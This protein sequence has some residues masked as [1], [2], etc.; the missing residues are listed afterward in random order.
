MS[1]KNSAQKNR[2]FL[3]S[4]LATTALGVA[5]GVAG[6]MFMLPYATSL[7][8]QKATTTSQSMS[9][10]PRPRAS[11][12]ATASALAPS[13]RA[14]VSFASVKSAAGIA[15]KAY[16]PGDAI[17]MGAV[18]TSDG[19]MA[20]VSDSAVF[21]NKSLAGVTAL[22]GG[23]AYKVSRM[24][25]DAYSGVTFLKADADNLPVTAFGATTT[26]AVGDSVF[27]AD[28]AGGLRRLE[29]LA[30]DTMPATVSDDLLRSSEKVQRVIRVTSGSASAGAMVLSGKGEIIGLVQGD[31]RFGSVV[32]P[33]EAFSDVIGAVLRGQSPQRPYLGLNYVDLSLIAGREGEEPAR[34][35]LVSASADG[36][37]AAVIKGS[38]AAAAGIRAG[39]LV[40][41]IDGE[42]VSGKNP[43]A[44]A[45]MQYQPGDKPTF[46]I[47]RGNA[48]TT[49][50]VIVT[51]GTAKNPQ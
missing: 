25:R 2:S 26:V 20:T 32:V 34:G 50:D 36:K 3:Q 41:A 1:E 45:L 51:L 38:P 47:Q 40:V 16:V 19:W 29:V 7:I 24:V 11:S 49:L 6:T 46:S 5:A 4:F 15:G 39:D 14:S 28:S 22:V 12:A 18:V 23:R 30:N 10:L 17:A 48:S 42:Q 35:A 43:L 27:V 37:T 44:D 8:V 33:V 31:G 21:K 9:D 13:A